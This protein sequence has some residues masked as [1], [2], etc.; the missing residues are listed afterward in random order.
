[1]VEFYVAFLLFVLGFISRESPLQRRED[2]QLDGLLVT[3]HHNYIL[4]SHHKQI[5]DSRPLNF[6][7]VKLGVKNMKCAIKKCLWCNVMSEGF[8]NDLMRI[9]RVFGGRT[10][11]IYQGAIIGTR[12]VLNNIFLL[13]KNSWLVT[14]PRGWCLKTAIIFPYYKLF[15]HKPTK[16]YQKPTHVHMLINHAKYCKNFD[17]FFLKLCLNFELS[18]KWIYNFI[19]LFQIDPE[20]LKFMN[21]SGMFKNCWNAK[22]EIHVN[23]INLS[24]RVLIL[25][26]CI[27]SQDYTRIHVRKVRRIFKQL[28]FWFSW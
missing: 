16:I 6:N 8:S 7:E 10:R 26:I 4:L 22:P 27:S 19:S 14:Q 11:V 13:K 5:N 21:F 23:S 3:K 25:F 28:A 18:Q 24:L 1:M 12:L 9:C 20:I 15:F 2:K 17:D